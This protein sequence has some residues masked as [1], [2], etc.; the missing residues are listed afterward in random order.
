MCVCIAA[1]C[2]ETFPD[3]LMQVSNYNTARRSKLLYWRIRQW[4]ILHAVLLLRRHVA[5]FIFV[6]HIYVLLKVPAGVG[7]F[8]DRYKEP[9]RSESQLCLELVDIE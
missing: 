6:D 2:V 7:L 8:F 4:H 5:V 1:T 9:L 3:T